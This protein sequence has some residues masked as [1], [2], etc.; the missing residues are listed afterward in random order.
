MK[1]INF[2][3]K[4]L[5]KHFEFMRGMSV[6]EKKSLIR[7]L[8]NNIENQSNKELGIKSFYGA[9]EDQENTQ[10]LIDTLKT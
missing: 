2:S 5:N 3:N 10:D 6:N 8:S 9:W 7:D 4:M 1:D